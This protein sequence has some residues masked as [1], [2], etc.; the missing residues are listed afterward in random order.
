MGHS[1]TTALGKPDSLPSTNCND[2]RIERALTQG[3]KLNGTLRELRDTVY[4]KMDS[5]LGPLPADPAK[6]EMSDPACWIE[7][8]TAGQETSI[9]IA[10]EILDRMNAV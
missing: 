4:A 2:E 3:N 10:R 5:L 8:I 9:D 1:N 7:R 6:K